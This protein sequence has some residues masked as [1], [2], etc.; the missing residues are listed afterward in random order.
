MLE[1]PDKSTACCFTG[2]RSIP[3]FQLANVELH[4]AKA[5]K[6]LADMGYTTFISG[7]AV[8]FDLLAAGIV[9]RLKAKYPQLRLVMV[10]PCKNQDAKWN[11][12]QKNQYQSVLAHSD[13]VICL[14]EN[15]FSGCMHI[16]NRF[17]VN[18]SNICI[19][20][21]THNSGGTAYTVRYA[22]ENKLGVINI[23]QL[24]T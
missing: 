3:A 5:I 4:T 21:L 13:D 24:I 19:A 20:Y 10:L 8:G 9:L 14:S 7:G 6:S 18:H 2:H 12:V 17:M 11:L 23:A 1:M 16:R 15:Y 22:E